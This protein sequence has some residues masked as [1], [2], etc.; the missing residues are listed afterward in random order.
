MLR[1]VSGWLSKRLP[2]A[3]LGEVDDPRSLRG[4]RRSM[5]SVLCSVVV[6]MV[7][8][9]RS[10]AAVE[11]VTA[12]MAPRMRRQLGLKGILPDTTAR[13]LL[14]RMC[15]MSIRKALHRVVRKAHQRKALAAEGLPMGMVAM[16]GKATALPTWEG[17]YAQRQTIDGRG[18]RGVLRTVTAALVSARA[19]PCIDAYPIPAETNEMGVFGAAFRALIE[20]YPRSSGLFQLVS[21]DSGACSLANASVVVGAGFDYLFALKG[22]QPTLRAEAERHL[23]HRDKPDAITE[24][25]TGS[26]VVVRRV[27]VS[28]DMEGFLD[29][30]HLRAFV[31]VESEQVDKHGQ[32]L[33]REN[34]YFLS[35]FVPERLTAAQWLRAVRA[36]W[37]VENQCHHTLDA[38]L[39]E[40]ENPW[41][42]YDS[43]GALAVMLLRRIALTLLALFRSVTQRSDERRQ[44]PW[45]DLLRAVYQALLL[46]PADAESDLGHHGTLAFP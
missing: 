3:R 27:F 21:Y 28:S 35:S 45:R 20:A 8:G 9:C 2:E 44:T 1:R 17:P 29:W 43:N 18:V 26:N 37:G 15:P 41:I 38:V 22:D 7:A 5:A 6:G 16:D 24:D 19:C 30:E 23:A 32:V 39:R 25:V 13:D 34:R 4:R 46:A 31:R 12:E 42:E 40:D 36:H 10:L 11:Q 14:C 33:A